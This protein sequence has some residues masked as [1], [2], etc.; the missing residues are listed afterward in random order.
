MEEKGKYTDPELGLPASSAAHLEGKPPSLS[1]SS[2]S[3]SSLPAFEPIRAASTRRP[4][5]DTAR[6]KAAS[7]QRSISNNGYG[8]DEPVDPDTSF[9][10]PQSDDEKDPFEVTWDP[11][12]RLNPRNMTLTKKWI[13]ITITS[14]GSFIVTNASAT[15]TAT[16]GQMA[17]EFH[18]SRLVA[19]IGLSTFVLGIALGPFWSP[20]AEFY[21]RRPI[22]LASFLFFM[23]F[24]I[25][26]ALAQNIQTMVIARFFQGLAGSA[27]LS[28]S[29]GTVGDMFSREEMQLP[30]AIFTLAPFIG[31]STGPLIGGVT[32]S[33]LSWRWTHYIVLIESAVLIVSLWFFV[34]ETYHPVLLTRK[35]QNLRRTTGNPNFYAPTEKMTRSVLSVVSHS[36][37]RP[38]QILLFEPMA[39]ILDVYSAILL[40]LLYL[41]FGAFPLVFSTNYGFN[42]WQV[43]LTFMG[44]LLAMPLAIMT[45]PF[46]NRYRNTLAERRGRKSGSGSG[47]GEP[48]G[49]PEDQL[50][51]VVVAAPLITGGLFWFGFTT[52]PWIHWIVPIIGSFVFGMG[53]MLAFTGIFTFLVD[54]YP[55]YAAST[56]AGN[57]LVRCSFAAAFPL[58][59][60]QMYEGL[61]FQWATGVLAFLTL[62]ML[63][64]PY[65]FFR[66]GKRIRAR[67]KFATS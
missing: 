39:L 18:S 10:E 57:A 11:S 62:A 4:S 47:S 36:L 1:S 28:V 15:Y 31:P 13:I 52:Y 19:T 35:A 23:I 20:L 54:A 55:R 5:R 24:L 51:M 8:C 43:G 45:M 53:T 9:P 48:E 12:D 17:P 42:L 2:S 32:N 3:P 63:P 66:Y 56:L 29:G 30:M 67:S 64:F 27:F 44:L 58:F 14:F 50:P 61:G 6:S 46:W 59:G 49:E 26:S 22:Y 21:G 25:P 65:I 38:F 40:G 41:F 34:P 33:F 7:L 37:L 60:I 16:Y